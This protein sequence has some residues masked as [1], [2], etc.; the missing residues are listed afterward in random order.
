MVNRNVYDI[1]G[2]VNH[3]RSTSEQLMKHHEPFMDEALELAQEALARGDWPVAAVIVN[4][5]TVIASGQGRQN[6]QRDPTWHAEVEA[7][8]GARAAGADLAGATLYCTMEPCP[9]CAWAIRLS[10]IA[11]V[12]LGARHA[13]LHR[14]DL[15]GYSLEA[16]ASLMG[17]S[18]DLVEGVRRAECVGLRERWGKD[19]STANAA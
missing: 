4:H 7:I 18:L 16:F 19:A 15:G 5:D 17:Y 8:R 14:T 11:R 9:M 10:G 1:M 12:V 6:T 13:D 2:I 3:H